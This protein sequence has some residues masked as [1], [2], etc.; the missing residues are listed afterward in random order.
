MRFSNTPLTSS[1]SFAFQKFHHFF[2]SSS[3]RRVTTSSIR[4]ESRCAR[5]VPFHPL[6]RDE[7]Y[8]VNGCRH[9]GACKILIK[10]R[11]LAKRPYF[12]SHFSFPSRKCYS[13]F[14][15]SWRITRTYNLYVFEKS[16]YKVSINYEKL[17]ILQP[18]IFDKI[19]SWSPNWPLI[20]SSGH[21][22]SL[23]LIAFTK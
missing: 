17:Y 3:K 11:Y 4:D 13:F 9:D 20:F 1:T 22:Y 8:T 15:H 2:V 21:N 5:K 12:T 16:K 14:F 7:A 18:F 23:L 10:V 6:S 19:Q